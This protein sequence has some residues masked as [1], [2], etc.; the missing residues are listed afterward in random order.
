MMERIFGQICNMTFTAS[1]VIL[2]VLVV[3]LLLNK[4]PRVLSYGLWSVVLFRLLCPVSFESVFSLLPS[5]RVVQS[6]ASGNSFRLTTNLPVLDQP[7]N[8]YLS[9]HVYEGVTVSAG[10]LNQLVHWLAICWLVG[11]VLLL[12]ASLVSLIQLKRR[13]RHAVLLEPGVFE[14]SGLE[15]AFVLGLFRPAIYLPAGLT[16]EERQYI[17]LHERTHIR[18][19]DPIIRLVSFLALCLHWFNPLVWLAFFLS[20]RDME[21][22]CDEAVIRQLGNEVKKGYSASLLSLASGRRWIGGVP[23]AFG[24]GDTGSRIRHVLSYRRPAFWVLLVGLAGVVAAVGLLAANPQIQPGMQWL[25]QLDA[26]QVKQIELVAMPGDSEGQYTLYTDPEE[27]SSIVSMLQQ[28]RGQYE[29]EPESLVG[30][31][32]TFYIIL[33]DGT[34]HTVTNDGN[35]Y[36]Y[37]DDEAYKASHSWLESWE[38]NYKGTEEIPPYFFVSAAEQLAEALTE[39]GYTVSEGLADPNLYPAERSYNL[40]L[41]NGETQ[42]ISVYE[43]VSADMALQRSRSTDPDGSSFIIPSGWNS[44][45]N[46]LVEWVAPP[47]FYLCDNM[48]AIYVGED[49]TILS[50]LEEMCGEPFAGKVAE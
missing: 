49:E 28:G 21:M 22:A 6:T 29:A 24:E 30:G 16:L 4:A 25:R 5:T 34:Q 2:A 43:F 20:G 31:G 1:M 18:H 10:Q 36:L 26:S 19:G 40:V 50:I 11:S 7:V 39:A 42:V 15:T 35:V 9:D 8:N 48:I 23:L 14:I 12:G 13:L 17:L 38:E 47:R 45:N 37:I 3:R 44:F 41:E 46:V 32:R 27:I 33:T